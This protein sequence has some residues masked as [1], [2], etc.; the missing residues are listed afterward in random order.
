MAYT[1][2]LAMEV[3]IASI[4]QP[5]Q[6]CRGRS[7]C[8]MVHSYCVVLSGAVGAAI[9]LWCKPRDQAVPPVNDPAL[10]RHIRYYMRRE[11]KTVGDAT[12]SVRVPL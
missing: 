3:F 2:V 11:C 8:R 7:A 5:E 12:G 6:S 1:R 4:V 10:C 9:T